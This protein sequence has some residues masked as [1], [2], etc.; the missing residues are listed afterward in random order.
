MKK[1]TRK[2]AKGF[3]LIELVI[4]V[5]IIAI[6]GAIAI[7]KMSRGA[8]GAADSALTQDLAVLHSALDLYNTEHPTAQLSSSTTIAGVTN[9]LTLYSDASG[10]TNSS[11]TTVFIYGPYLKQIP[12]MPV[13]TNKNSSTITITGPAGTTAG[14]GWYFTGTDFIA[15]NPTAD[16]DVSGK[17]YNLY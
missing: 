4:V 9:A 14:A 11:K 16:V 5:V 1:Q 12:S 10:N 7:P 13:G 8:S 17:A 3:S 15:N 2:T 6:I